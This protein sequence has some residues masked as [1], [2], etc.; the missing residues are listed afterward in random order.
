M[1]LVPKVLFINGV[2]KAELLSRQQKKQVFFEEIHNKITYANIPSRIISKAD[3]GRTVSARCWYCDLDFTGIEIFFP[4]VI[5]ETQ[6]LA[7][8]NFNSFKCLLSYINVYYSS[9]VDEIESINKAMYL[10]NLFKRQVPNFDSSFEPA[11]SKYIM[12]KY[13]GTLQEDDYRAL[14]ESTCRTQGISLPKIAA[15]PANSTS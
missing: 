2:K 1:S 12:A 7:E 13:G 8:G 11:L 6:F 3:V 14:I 9:S 10:Y 15:S 5:E 4:K